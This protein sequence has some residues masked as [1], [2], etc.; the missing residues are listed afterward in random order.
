VFKVLVVDDESGFRQ[1]MQVILQ[2]AGYCVLQ[3]AD[4]REALA[5][6][7]QELPVCVILDDMMPG[8]SGSEL[9]RLMK[10]D[11]RLA[12]VPVLMHTANLKWDDPNYVKEIGADGVL[13]KPCSPREIVDAVSRFVGARA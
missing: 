2:R 11:A 6:L 7:S 1:I 3:A 13:I 12:L 9:C 4:A 10:S 5:V 8:M